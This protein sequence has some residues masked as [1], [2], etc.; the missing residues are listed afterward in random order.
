MSELKAEHA[1]CVQVISSMAADPA[2]LD[3]IAECLTRIDD[4]NHAIIRLASA[5]TAH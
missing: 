3:R 5:H 4:I 2:Y 1:A